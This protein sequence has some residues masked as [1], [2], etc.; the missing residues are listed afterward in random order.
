MRIACLGSGSKGNSLLVADQS[1]LLMVDCGFPL[2][3]TERRLARLG[4][5]PAAITA[6]L[7]THEHSDHIS[8]VGPLAR[9]YNLP[10]MLSQGSYLAD[11]CGTIRALQ[12][13]RSEQPVSFGRLRAFPFSVPHDAREPLQWV[14]DN[15]EQ[16]FA[17]VTDLGHPT[18]FVCEQIGACDVLMLE[19]NHDEQMLHSGRYPPALKRRVGG[20]YG[21]LSNAQ[22][23]VLLEGLDRQRLRMV[24]AAHLSEENNQPILA[25]TALA[26]VLGWQPEEVGVAGQ[27]HGFDWITIGGSDRP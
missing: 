7:V 3:E 10:V 5:E 22:S 18:P 25:Q 17:L 12:I 2:T 9:R 14:F 27:Q 4:V 21:H 16:R 19:C 20:D 1:T 15:G 6:I 11:R 13:M 26:A 23:A 8:G 24:I